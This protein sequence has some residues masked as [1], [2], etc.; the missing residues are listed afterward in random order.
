[1]HDLIVD[2]FWV[3]SEGVRAQKLHS[4][5]RGVAQPFG[6][7]PATWIINQKEVP[8]LAVETEQ[9]ALSRGIQTIEEFSNGKNQIPQGPVQQHDFQ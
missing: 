4:R 8:F 7:V 5:W 1:M 6:M 9:H 2:C 3:L